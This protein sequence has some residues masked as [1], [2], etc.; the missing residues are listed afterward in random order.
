MSSSIIKTLS[1]SLL[2]NFFMEKSVE[3]NH[4]V[5]RTAIPKTPFYHCSINRAC[6]IIYNIDVLFRTFQYSI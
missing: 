6:Y 4:D 2:L 5:Y 3:I 1:T